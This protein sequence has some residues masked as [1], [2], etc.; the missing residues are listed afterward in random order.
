MG[1]IR[2]TQEDVCQGYGDE[3]VCQYEKPQEKD[4]QREL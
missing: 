4:R 1:T 2:K 3:G